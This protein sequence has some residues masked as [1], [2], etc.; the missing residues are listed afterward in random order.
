MYIEKVKQGTIIGTV[1]AMII[2]WDR[3]KSILLA[4]IHGALNWL[5]IIYYYFFLKESK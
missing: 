4:I 1:L 2:S 5:Y 3:N